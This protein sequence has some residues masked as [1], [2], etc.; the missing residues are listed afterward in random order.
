MEQAALDVDH[1][2]RFAR[3]VEA[4]TLLALGCVECQLDLVA[5]PEGARRRDDRLRNEAPETSDPPEG[6]GENHGL[7]LA[8]IG[9]TEDHPGASAALRL[10]RARGLPAGTRGCHDLHGAGLDQARPDVE[11]L[12]HDAISGDSPFDHPDH[13]VDP[14]DAP[15]PRGKAIDV[16]LLPKALPDRH[17]NIQG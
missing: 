11:R 2:E 3:G 14:A 17:R 12:R 16:D 4:Q 13:A 6:V 7:P 5:I 1:A 10:D 15:S 9:L 8:L